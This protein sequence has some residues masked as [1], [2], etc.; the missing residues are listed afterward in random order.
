MRGLEQFDQQ[1]REFVN[2][3]KDWIDKEM[4]LRQMLAKTSIWGEETQKLW[5]ERYEEARKAHNK[6][7][8][9]SQQIV[10]SRPPE[11]PPDSVVGYHR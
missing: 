8:E 2:T 9:L 3:A 11:Q 4:A 5:R 1:S 6:L 10:A 7:M